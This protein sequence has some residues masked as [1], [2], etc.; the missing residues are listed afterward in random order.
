MT[1]TTCIIK[2]IGRPTLKDAIA[3]AHREGFKPIVISD[4]VNTSAQN[5]AAFIKLGKKWGMYG[6]MCANVA[7]AIAP[8]EFIT[9]LDDDDQFLPGA[10]NKIRSKLK[11]NTDIDIWIGGVRFNAPIALFDADGNEVFRGNDLAMDP[12]RGLTLGNVAMPTYRTKVFATVPFTDTI[13]DDLSTMTDIYHVRACEARGF[14]VGWFCNAGEL[15]LYHV[16][17][18]MAKMELDEAM[19]NGRGA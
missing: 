2:T 16:R 18:H 12:R 7:A 11:Q 10:G 19:V 14:K 5:A 3:S 15:P 6:G 8:T 17:P 1:E 9:F 13:P 4:G